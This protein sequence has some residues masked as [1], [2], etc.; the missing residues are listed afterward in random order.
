MAVVTV[1]Y[2]PGPTGY[3][4]HIP[5][6]KIWEQQSCHWIKQDITQRVE[7]IIA[8]IV[9]K[10]QCLLIHHPDKTRCPAPV[11]DINAVATNTGIF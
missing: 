9:R 2:Y 1:P 11:G 3:I 4:Q 6:F 5:G 10:G 8:G 7:M